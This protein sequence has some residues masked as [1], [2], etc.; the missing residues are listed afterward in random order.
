M[1]GVLRPML[2]MAAAFL[3]G[4]LAWWQAGS[5][6]EGAASRPALRVNWQ[7]RAVEKQDLAAVDAV[8]KERA[9]WGAPAGA[10]ASGEAE[11]APP[12]PSIPVGVVV[13]G[14]GF[15][16]V[17]VTPGADEVRVRAGDRLPD[18]GRV[19]AVSRFRIDWIDAQGTKHEQELLSD[20]LLSVPTASSPMKKADGR[21]SA[22]AI[23]R[24]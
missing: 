1:R 3:L 10:T 19:T 7:L 2:G 17:F 15:R 4:A 5:G 13:V 9:P 18:G 24:R 14:R 22:G 6:P 8:W 16:A 12:P 21:P 11:P 23:S 20:P